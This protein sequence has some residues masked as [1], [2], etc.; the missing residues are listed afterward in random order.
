MLRSDLCDYS[1]TYIVVKGTISVEGDEENKK[2]KIKKYPLRIMLHLD[3]AYQK[4]ITH[5]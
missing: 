3:H 4:S 1:D 5:L 2:K